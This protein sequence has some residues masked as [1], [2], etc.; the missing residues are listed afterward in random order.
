VIFTANGS[1]Y[2]GRVAGDSIAFAISGA[3][4]T[5]WNAKKE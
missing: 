4:S 5:S 1:T 3:R 2:T